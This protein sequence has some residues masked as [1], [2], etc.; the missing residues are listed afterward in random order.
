[1]GDGNNYL[2]FFVACS[3]TLLFGGK[4]PI[5]PTDAGEHHIAGGRGVIA[6]DPRQ[7]KSG[8]VWGGCAT[9]KA[10]SDRYGELEGHQLHSRVAGSKEMILL[11]FIL[12]SMIIAEGGFDMGPLINTSVAAAVLMFMLVKLEPRLR[13]IESSIDR[14][15]RALL[16]IVVSHPDSTGVQQEQA[17]EIL[18]ELDEKKKPE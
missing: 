14:S 12:I 9:F 8:I 11:P 13:A 1:M 7:R 17:R 2:G 10:H 15:A 3:R 18:K 16:L 5:H 6:R 4:S